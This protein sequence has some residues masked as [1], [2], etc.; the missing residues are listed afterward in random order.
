M[1]KIKNAKEKMSPPTPP[2]LM[3]PFDVEDVLS[4]LST[5]EKIDLLSGNVTISLVYK[6]Y[7]SSVKCQ[8]H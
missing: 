5:T 3:E 1:G 2:T 7:M 8:C 6:V 4:K